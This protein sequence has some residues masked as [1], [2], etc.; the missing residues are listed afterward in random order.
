LDT[1]SY[2][3]SR[4]YTPLQGEFQETSQFSCPT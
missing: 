2:V 1:S 4:S 3:S